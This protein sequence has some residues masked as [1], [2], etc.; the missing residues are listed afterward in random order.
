MSKFK[1][2]V[3][4]G[5]SVALILGSLG[6]VL[7]VHAVTISDGDLVKTANSSAV[8]YIQGS[9]KRVFPHANVYS[10]WGYTNF[11]GV[12]VVSASDLATYT[13]GNAMP[14]RDGSLF[15]GFSTGISGYAPE[16]VYYV[17]DAK[18]R[19]V[20]SSDIYQALFND[21]NWNKVTWVPNDLLAKFTYPLGTM[22]ESSSTHPDGSLVKYT[23][24]T[25]KYL[26]SGGQK[27]SHFRRGLH[28]QS[29]CGFKCCDD[30]LFRGLR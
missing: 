21:A 18:I 8:Y 11:N 29:L 13:E 24:T 3:Y 14:F 12:K 4:V 27:K 5:A 16:A 26:I 30:C 10:S 6:P 25:Q 20:K 23:G 2:L 19:P 15:R 9:T 7:T 22:I 1:K 17:Q 28:G